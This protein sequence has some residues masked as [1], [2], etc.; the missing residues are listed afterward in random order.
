VSAGLK[1]NLEV[2][3]NHFSAFRR[4]VFTDDLDWKLKPVI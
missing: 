1:R 2:Q 4:L 3:V